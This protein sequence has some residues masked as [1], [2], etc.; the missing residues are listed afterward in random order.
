MF[1]VK[2]GLNS[3]RIEHLIMSK[4]PILL[5]HGALGSEAQFHKLKSE[6]SELFDVH[7]LIFE[8]HG[9]RSSNRPFSMANFVENAVEYL[10]QNETN[11][12]EDALTTRA[13]GALQTRKEKGRKEKKGKKEKRSWKRK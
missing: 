11:Q 9:G 4:S 8:G 13:S 7:T 1:G 10:D 2:K 6:L 5:L 12:K 3:D